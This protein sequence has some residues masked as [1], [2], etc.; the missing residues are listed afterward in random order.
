MK[1]KGIWPV[2]PTPLTADEEI[3]EPGLRRVV[4]YAIQGGV[5]GLWM[6]GSGGEQPMLSLEAQRRVLE[7]AVEEAKGHVPVVAGVGAPSL[8]QALVNL[9]MAQGA[10]VDAVQ[11]VEPY[12][13]AFSA[14]ELVDYFETLAT[15]ADVPM[16]F[17]H[18]PGRWPAGS[19]SLAQL[20]LTLG[21]LARHPNI[22]AMK[23]INR[24][25]RDVQRVIFNLASD[26][27]TVLTAAGRLLFSTL[28][29]GGHGGVLGQAAI[30]PRH[31]VAVYEAFERGDFLQARELQ[32]GLS[33]LG[34]ALY[35]YSP[36]LSVMKHAL[37][38]LGLCEPHVARP[39]HG[40]NEEAKQKMAQAMTDLGLI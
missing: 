25:P 5:H 10:G 8:R 7:I 40:A 1:I 24:D 4:R 18:A 29:I 19:T 23:Y 6:L 21:R 20:P 28:M 30:A 9:E 11:S 22:I 15:A 38:L 35:E 16:V 14:D 13:F 33:G 27:F 12:Y 26:D 2:L 17:Y 34:D 37:S 32:R 36:G 31:F 39:R 3:D